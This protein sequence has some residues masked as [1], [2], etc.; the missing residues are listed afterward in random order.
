MK[1]LI[2][3]LA[4]TLVLAFIGPAFTQQTKNLKGQSTE[5]SCK[6]AGGKWYSGSCHEE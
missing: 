4:V 6:A 2:S 1:S 3:I 5:A